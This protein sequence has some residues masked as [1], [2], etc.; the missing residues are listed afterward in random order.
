[1][2]GAESRVDPM[3]FKSVFVSVAVFATISTAMAAQAAAYSLVDVHA[4]I[5]ATF[6]AA[7]GSRA[8]GVNAS[9]VVVGE[10]YE[11]ISTI[12]FVYA[13]GGVQA[14]SV[15]PTDPNPL[16][17]WNCR[18]MA[19]NDA[20]TVAGGCELLEQQAQDPFSF[21]QME[22]RAV[23]W[24]GDAHALTSIPPLPGGTQHLAIAI[25]ERDQVVGT[26]QV[27]GNEL[28]TTVGRTFAW[29]ATCG[30]RSLDVIRGHGFRGVISCDPVAIDGAGRIGGNCY[31]ME[32][33]RRLGFI[34]AAGQTKAL[35]AGKGGAEIG[36]VDMSATGVILGISQEPSVHIWVG[37]REHLT[38]I[39][40]LDGYFPV[41]IV[42]SGAIL[43]QD[44]GVSSFVYNGG[45]LEPVAGPGTR[46]VD[47]AETGAVA[48]LIVAPAT[49][50]AALW[51]P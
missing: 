2:G 24:S 12:G 16:R 9:G 10:F 42:K 7:H 45:V 47:M 22:L 21:T 3:A 37:N 41:R 6:P 13:N 40:A 8:T 5:V 27:A 48:G 23:V 43:V 28:F 14:L 50:F 18:P 31:E 20:G 15:P 39:P 49:V 34:N 29:D 51:L 1:M 32:T 11:G 35:P 19:V 26:Y 36:V 44:A 46:T 4:A 17:H 33:G 25:N 30:V 38:L